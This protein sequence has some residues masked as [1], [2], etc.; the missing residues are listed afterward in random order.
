MKHLL[1]ALVIV[2]SFPAF[3]QSVRCGQSHRF[4]TELIMI[5]DSE[6][7]VHQVAGR[8]DLERRLENRQGGA[9]GFRLDYH[10]HGQTVQIY[11]QAGVV[12]RICRVRD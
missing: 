7:R 12:T 11:V 8:P 3:G 9:A 10:Q 1:I 4:G 5:G 2:L 6:R